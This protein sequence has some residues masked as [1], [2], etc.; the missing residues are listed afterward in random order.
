MNAPV[1]LA[2]LVQGSEEWIAARVG[3]LGASRMQ[4]AMA[5]IKTGWG[6]SRTNLM[7]ELIAEKLTGKPAEHFISADMKWGTEQEPA[8]RAAYE[9]FTNETIVPVGMIVHPRISGA[10][11]SPDGLVGEHG[12]VEFKCPLTATHLETLL[13]GSIP[14]KYMTQMQW[15]LACSRREWSDYVS[16]DPRLPTT[17]QM[18]I[19][20]IPRDEGVIATLEREVPIF[21]DELTRKL[22]ELRR[23]YG[24]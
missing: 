20:K 17:M 2:K 16:F 8:A 15:A 21:L 23:R 24:A 7:A 1:D 14:L 13:G 10:H 18:S 6:T 9:F 4:E 3:S 5:K 11:A 22:T 19:T 12:L